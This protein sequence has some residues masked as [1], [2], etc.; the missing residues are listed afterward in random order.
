MATDWS[1]SVWGAAQ[2]FPVSVL[3]FLEG[4]LGKTGKNWGKISPGLNNFGNFP[5][6]PQFFPIFPVFPNFPNFVSF[7]NFPSFFQFFPVPVLPFWEGEL[8]KTGSPP[9]LRK[10]SSIYRN[11]TIPRSK[12]PQSKSP[13]QIFNRSKSPR[14]VFELESCLNVIIVFPDADY[15]NIKEKHFRST[16]DPFLG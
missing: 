14:F 4:K 7:P 13:S 10:F 9:C 3:G 6:F 8:G 12:S 11:C 15:D 5:H 1:K 2:F 16:Y